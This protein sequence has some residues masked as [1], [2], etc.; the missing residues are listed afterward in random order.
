MVEKL[1]ARLFS[2]PLLRF[3]RLLFV[4][5]LRSSLFKRNAKRQRRTM[6]LIKRII[7]SVEEVP[8]EIE[9][10]PLAREYL[11]AVVAKVTEV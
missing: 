9:Q 11:N 3:T 1:L 10:R 8:S 2:L 6:L 5:L 4:F 7:T